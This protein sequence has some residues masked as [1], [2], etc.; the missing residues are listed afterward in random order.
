M[1]DDRGDCG[2]TARTHTHTH[3]PPALPSWCWYKQRASADQRGSNS[4]GDSL[5]RSL[6][7]CLCLVKCFLGCACFRTVHRYVTGNYSV[8]PADVSLNNS[9]KGFYQCE[10]ICCRFNVSTE[11]TPRSV[12]ICLEVSKTQSAGREI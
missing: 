6:G 8:D 1:Y 10:N 4:V 9:I 12:S 11:H 7:F 5:C 3:T 2:T